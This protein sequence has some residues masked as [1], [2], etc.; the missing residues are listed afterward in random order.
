M[1]SNKKIVICDIDGT[2]ANN[3]HRQ[4]YLEGKKD[5]EG[6]FNSADQDK[7]IKNIIQEVISLQ[8]ENFEVVF[9]SGR[10]EL[11]RDLTLKWLAKY[12]YFEINLIMRKNNDKR[13]KVS[14]K[15]EIYNDEFKEKEIHLV[16]E[17]DPKLVEMWLS[18]DLEV[19][20]V[21]LE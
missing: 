17:N 18:M 16:F 6:F 4:H 8:K 1:S 13:D 11:Y 19:R 9:V 21:D 7:P 14:V 12:F 20:F 5:W 10:P 2:I 15:K 3:K